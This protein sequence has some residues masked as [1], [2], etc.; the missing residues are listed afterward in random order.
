MMGTKSKFRLWAIALLCLT[1]FTAVAVA[2]TARPSA[3]TAETTTALAARETEWLK[4]Y[5]FSYADKAD[6]VDGV[7][8]WKL[9]S[10][11]EYQ[12]Y[13]VINEDD[14]SVMLDKGTSDPYTTNIEFDIRFEKICN[15]GAGFTILADT[16]SDNWNKIGVRI[17][18]E[19]VWSMSWWNQYT[20]HAYNND[21]KLSAEANNNGTIN[22]VNTVFHIVFG[23][24]HLDSDANEIYF[25]MS[26][27][28][29]G[30]IWT[31]FTDTQ[32]KGSAGWTE[33]KPRILI[34]TPF[35]GQNNYTLFVRDPQYKSVHDIDN[36][37]DISYFWNRNNNDPISLTYSDSYE[38]KLV[39]DIS[40]PANSGVTWKMNSDNDDINMICF[41]MYNRYSANS[42]N[43]AVYKDKVVFTMRDG[44]NRTAGRYHGTDA[45]PYG[46]KIVEFK[47]EKPFTFTKT[48]DYILKFSAQDVLNGDGAV[49]G[50]LLTYGIKAANDSEFVSAQAFTSWVSPNSDDK[51]GVVLH[52]STA[53]N[54][55]V[56]ISSTGDAWYNIDYTDGS[57]VSKQKA[58]G[59]SALKV[60]SATDKIFVGWTDGTDL[61][62]AGDVYVDGFMNLTAVYIDNFYAPNVANL[63]MASA[64]LRFTGRI[65]A[66]TDVWTKLN[67]LS[68]KVKYVMKITPNG[69]AAT[70]TVKQYS[71]LSAGVSKS[72]TADTETVSD[73]TKTYAAQVYLRVTYANNSAS[74]ATNTSGQTDIESPT[75]GAKNSVGNIAAKA[76]ADTDKQWNTIERRK[77]EE[78]SGQA[79]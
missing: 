31:E 68:D 19:E 37:E 51:I 4:P 42:Y 15:N 45:A 25:K 77:L 27:R 12:G 57:S 43:F 66:T 59:L 47:F 28:D 23:V 6:Q 53:V 8:T 18:A 61:Y 10:Q 17:K 72:F 22:T 33:Y 14:G 67:N 26:E 78:L 13:Q 34:G 30:T 38:E 63:N 35:D 73:Y 36:D 16:N 74:A 75:S 21:N 48:T 39:S 29:S 20:T 58:K 52:A 50:R 76:L 3:A 56:T 55:T 70:E 32:P 46:D 79:A 24:R 71:D 5:G 62:K 65:E 9:D 49:V 60:P 69:S 41:N 64:K 2:L 1:V 7:A 40:V 11:G 44:L 54:R